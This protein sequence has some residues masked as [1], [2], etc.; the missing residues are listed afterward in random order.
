M[1]VWDSKRCCENTSRQA[2]VSTLFPRTLPNFHECCFKKTYSFRK[3]RDEKRKHLWPWKCQLLANCVL[4]TSTAV[5]S[6]V[7]LSSYR[8]VFSLLSFFAVFSMAAWARI[9][10]VR[11][12]TETAWRQLVIYNKETLLV[13]EIIQSNQNTLS[14]RLKVLVKTESAKIVDLAIN[15][16]RKSQLFQKLFS[17]PALVMTLFYFRIFF[18]ASYVQ[19]DLHSHWKKAVAKE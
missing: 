14:S 18:I 11:K 1:K 5:A 17:L 9:L 2:S 16:W 19:L 6:S 13:P 7:L 12:G 4:I 3:F 10:S 8:R 15:N